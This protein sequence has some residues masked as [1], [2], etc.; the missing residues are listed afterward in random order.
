MAKPEKRFRCGGCEAA[1]FENEIN[2][3]GST[4]KLK[5]VAFQ[6]R[7][8]TP[9]G[10]WRSTYSL[11]INDIPKAVLAL[12]KAYEYLVLGDNSEADGEPI[13]GNRFE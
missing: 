1:I 5:K 4:V 7:Y 2:K 8:K 12:S 6:K 13:K 11:D 9:D 10:D 3:G